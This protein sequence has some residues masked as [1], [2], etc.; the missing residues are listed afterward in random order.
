M[1]GIQN[2]PGYLIYLAKSTSVV[3]H[4]FSDDLK[5]SNRSAESLQEFCK[6]N[7]PIRDIVHVKTLLGNYHL[8]FHFDLFLEN[9]CNHL[10]DS[11]NELN[12]AFNNVPHM[13]AFEQDGDFR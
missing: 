7:K 9:C 6:K 11:F 10:S 13:S 8:V 4:L 3:L 5:S 12:L 1:Q 2:K